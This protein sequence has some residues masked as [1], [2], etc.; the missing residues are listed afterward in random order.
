MYFRTE[1]HGDWGVALP[2]DGNAIRFHLVIQ[3]QC[4]VT[5]DGEPVQLREGDF[6]LIPHGAAQ[7]LSDTPNTRPVALAHLI[8]DG[9]LGVDGVLRYGRQNSARQTRLVCGFCS[10]DEEL[11]HPLFLGLPPVVRMGQHTT[12]SSP[13]LAQSVRVIAMESDLNE[14][15]GA[16]VISRLLEVLFIQGIR[17]HSRSPTSTAIPF[18]VAI[19]DNQ[20]KRALEAMHAETS[21]PWSVGELAVLSGMSRGRFSQRFK[22]CVGQ[23]PLQYLTE[24]RLQKARRLL[25]ETSL[26]IAEVGHRSGYQSLPSF[27]RRFSKHFGTTPGAFRKGSN[28]P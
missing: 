7:V 1:F 6:A 26:S 4:W 19:T 22:D 18:M 3:G 24:W 17:H 2:A 12:G 25:K 11:N 14:I 8:Q 13:W 15:G 28:D 27:T 20:L 21:K 5:V 23:A 10:F 9:N 16:A